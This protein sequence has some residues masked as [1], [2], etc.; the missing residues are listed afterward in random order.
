MYLVDLNKLSLELM[1]GRHGAKE[2]RVM[3]REL[4]YTG[5]PMAS[6]LN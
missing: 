1:E 3:C 6:S 2:L 5:R 4:T